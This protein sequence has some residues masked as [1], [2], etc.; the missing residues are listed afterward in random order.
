MYEITPGIMQNNGE[1]W[2]PGGGMVWDAQ[3]MY[4]LRR[5]GLGRTD[6][7]WSAKKIMV[8][9]AQMICGL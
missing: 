5:N 7:V 9:N 6:D 2:P 4:G 3:M 1:W 8:E